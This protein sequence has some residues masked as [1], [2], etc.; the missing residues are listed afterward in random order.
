[1]PR[2]SDAQR[3][4][5]GLLEAGPLFYSK[6][7]WRRRGT[8]GVHPDVMDRLIECGSVRRIEQRRNCGFTVTLCRLATPGE[9]AAKEN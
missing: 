6:G 4:A 3:R 9:R 2:Q 5:V 7:R 1:M 8:D